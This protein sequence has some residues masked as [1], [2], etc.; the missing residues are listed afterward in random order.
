MKRLSKNRI[1]SIISSVV[2]VPLFAIAPAAAALSTGGPSVAQS[3]KETSPF[4]TNIVSNVGK[5]NSSLNAAKL[6]VDEARTERVATQTA[7]RAKWDQELAANRAKWDQQRQENFTKLEAK[8]TTD[9]QKTAVQ[10]YKKAITDAISTRRATNDKARADFRSA[11]DSLISGQNS[12]VNAQSVILTTTISTAISTAQAACYAT[13]A[14]GAT[15]RTTLQAGIKTAKETFNNARKSDSNLGDQIQKLAE[16]RNTT[17]K[18]NDSA[19]E[20]AAKAARDTLKAA[21][22]TNATI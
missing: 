22:G 12:T 15:I 19:F 14:E 11:V 20:A 7:N 18:A 17:I 4:C 10:T 21:F 8:A 5:I 16:T 1:A 6:K 2:A 13:P 3:V 9:A